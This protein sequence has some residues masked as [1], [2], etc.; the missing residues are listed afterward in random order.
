M[1]VFQ[2]SQTS[3]QSNLGS[4]GEILNRHSARGL[5]LA[6]LLLVPRYQCPSR[7]FTHPLRAKQATKQSRFLVLQLKL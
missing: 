1:L 3:H 2:P 7:A 4:S 5:E 6:N